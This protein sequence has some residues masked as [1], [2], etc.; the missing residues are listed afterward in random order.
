M[1]LAP[2]WPLTLLKI[3]RGTLF[4]GAHDGAAGTDV[5]IHAGELGKRLDLDVGLDELPRNALE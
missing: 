1:T 2:G 4:G 3:D 5:T